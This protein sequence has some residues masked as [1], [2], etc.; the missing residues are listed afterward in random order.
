MP[1][2]I[3]RVISAFLLTQTR[4]DSLDKVNLNFIFKKLMTEETGFITIYFTN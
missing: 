4:Q 1:E 2:S 3:A